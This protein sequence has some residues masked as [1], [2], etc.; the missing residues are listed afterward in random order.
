MSEVYQPK[1]H[2]DAFFNSC[3]PWKWQSV[4]PVM[5]EDGAH[6]LENMCL[7]SLQHELP[8]CYQIS[9]SLVFEKILSAY[10]TSKSK[11]K[12]CALMI[13]NLLQWKKDAFD[14][15]ERN[16]MIET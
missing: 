11:M 6:R 2:R 4:A 14:I 12:D 15:K 9:E 13:F 7:I 16:V 10:I 1:R 8:T 3:V 5:L